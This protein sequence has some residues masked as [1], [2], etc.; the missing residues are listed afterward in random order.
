MET[1]HL[2]TAGLA[3]RF[4]VKQWNQPAIDILQ[5][6]RQHL[7]ALFQ[8]MCTSNRTRMAEY[9]RPEAKDLVETDAYATRGKT[10][11]IKE[12]DLM[13]FTLVRTGSLWT[14]STTYWTEGG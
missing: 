4:I 12:D 6:P 10:K 2:P 7:P 8:P 3:D 14:K 5:A 11:E 9:E 1:M 13:I